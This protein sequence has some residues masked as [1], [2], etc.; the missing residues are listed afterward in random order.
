MLFPLQ[1]WARRSLTPNSIAPEYNDDDIT[2]PLAVISLTPNSMSPISMTPHSMADKLVF[3]AA[4]DEESVVEEGLALETFS[5]MIH[6]KMLSPKTIDL[7]SM[8]SLET[9]PPG[10]D[11]LGTTSPETISSENASE[12]LPSDTMIVKL[13]IRKEKTINTTKLFPKTPLPATTNSITAD[14]I[15]S[16]TMFEILPSTPKLSSSKNPKSKSKTINFNFM[17][18]KPEFIS[19]KAKNEII[20][21]KFNPLAKPFFPIDRTNWNDQQQR[22]TTP[23]HSGL[24]TTCSKRNQQNANRRI[25]VSSMNMYGKRQIPLQNC[26]SRNMN[27]AREFM[28]PTNFGC[29]VQS[30][31]PNFVA[32]NDLNYQTMG[33]N[34]VI[35]NLPG[36]ASITTRPITPRIMTAKPMNRNFIERTKNVNLMKRKLNFDGTTFNTRFTAKGVNPHLMSRSTNVNYMTKGISSNYTFKGMKSNFMVKGTKSNSVVKKTNPKYLF[37]GVNQNSKGKRMNTNYML[38]EADSKYIYKRTNTTRMLKGDSTFKSKGT[39]ANFMLKGSSPNFK[40]EEMNTNFSVKGM[41]PNFRGNGV[42]ETPKYPVNEVN[43]NLMARGMNSNFMATTMMNPNITATT[44]LASKAIEASKLTK[45]SATK[46]IVPRK[47]VPK[48]LIPPSALRDDATLYPFKLLPSLAEGRD[49]ETS[50]F[51]PFSFPLLY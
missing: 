13:I 10:P 11:S 47:V 38:N 33:S 41:N 48:K 49:L 22:N 25:P 17:S 37:E 35:I 12:S 28:R 29:T 30:I 6:C 23:S 20:P 51:L 39:N 27:V 7:E 42:T 50:T 14:L 18:S 3:I 15:V 46:E 1:S 36:P 40:S 32:A 43:P 26:M 45:N 19:S 16:K 34:F 4:I 21:L 8:S 5:E 44:T 9:K 2:C 31:V 24:Y